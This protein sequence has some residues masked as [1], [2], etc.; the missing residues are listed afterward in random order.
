MK[1]CETAFEESPCGHLVPSVII[2][3]ADDETGENEE[4]IHGQITMI[5]YLE[6]GTC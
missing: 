1:P 5:D 6:C 4:E 3:I 2:G